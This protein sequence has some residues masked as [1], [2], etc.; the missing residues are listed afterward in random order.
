V[1]LN[2]ADCAFLQPNLPILDPALPIEALLPSKIRMI[3]AQGNACGEMQ[4]AEAMRY[5]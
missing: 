5:A 1:V 2:L 4:S 3:G